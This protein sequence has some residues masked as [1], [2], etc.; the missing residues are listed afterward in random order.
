MTSRE[1]LVQRWLAL[2]REVLPAMAADAGWP[3]R[4]DHCF[5]RVCLDAACGE[6]W[7]QRIRRPAI[8]HA[9][10]ADLARAIATAEIIVANPGRLAA[11]NAQSLG[12]R[13]ARRAQKP[14]RSSAKTG[15]GGP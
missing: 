13:R 8:R 2:T 1:A 6:P 10:D 11:L 3:I 7:D 5:M 9:S 12:W 4:L 14:A 15:R